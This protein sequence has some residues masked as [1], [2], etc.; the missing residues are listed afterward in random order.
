MIDWYELALEPTIRRLGEVLRREFGAWVGF[1][2]PEGNQF[3]IGSA[4][5]DRPHLLCE[6]LMANALATEGSE[7]MTCRGSMERWVR[8]DRMSERPDPFKTCHAGLGALTVPVR[9]DAEVAGVVYASGFIAAERGEQ[10]VSTLRSTLVSRDFARGGEVDELIGS[11]PILDRTQRSLALTLVKSIVEECERVIAADPRRVE[12]VGDRYGDMIGTS[13][14]MKRLFGIL[15]KIARGDSTVLIRGENGTGKELIARAIHQHSRRASQPFIVQNCAAIPAD[16]IESEL[17]GHKKGAFSGA[18]RD[19]VGLFEAANHGT[20]FLDEIGEMD[21][22]LQVK[23]LRVLQEGTFLPVGDNVYRRV[24]VRVLCATNRDLKAMVDAGKFREDLYYRI[25]VISVDAPP[26]RHRRDDI[27]LLATYFLNKACHRHERAR[28]RLSREA[29]EALSMHAWP[30][31]VRELE[32]EIERAVIMTGDAPV[33][34]LADLSFA[35][36]P[37]DDVAILDISHGKLDLPEAVERLERQM[38]LEGLRRTGWNK[39]QTARE[40][41]VSRRNLIRKVAAYDLEKNRD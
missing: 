32:N 5:S 29:A 3:S 19:R 4:G 37:R 8:H 28:K 12:S 6:R 23:L 34:G 20:F 17:F 25:N 40:L 30:G 2:D 38:I 22:S 26:L 15:R 1:I 24:D 10:V 35:E 31:N 36:Q 39:T 27:P 16:L 21:V 14:E 9:R 11:V 18:H 13:D 41:G 7:V 33:V